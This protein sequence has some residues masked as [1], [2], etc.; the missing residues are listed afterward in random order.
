MY[1]KGQINIEFTAG[2]VLFFLTLIFVITTAFSILP[3]YVATTEQNKMENLGWALTDVLLSD[4]GYWK[5]SSTNGTDWENHINH[6]KVV[7]LVKEFQQLDPNKINALGSLNYNQLRYLLGLKENFQINI[8]EYV[9]IETLRF[10]EKGDLEGVIISGEPNSGFY[11]NAE[12]LIHFGTKI[13]NGTT[14]YFLVATQNQDYR[15]F[16]SQYSN[17]SAFTEYD[18]SWTSSEISF[19]SLTFNVKNGKTIKNSN[20]KL[21]I[22]ERPYFDYGGTTT[23][24]N[25]RIYVFRRFA[26]MENQMVEVIF[27]LW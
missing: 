22:L 11:A 4:S 2:A 26:E 7:G 23:I 18:P 21:L 17:F 15:V 27:T 19:N 13:I 10:F 20:G 12:S 3:K 6:I 14:F 1:K 9:I 16:V 25:E 8:K 24:V 5:N